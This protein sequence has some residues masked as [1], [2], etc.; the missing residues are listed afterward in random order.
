MQNTKILK[1]VLNSGVGQAVNNPQF[2]ENT[3]QILNKIA[4]GQKPILTK[5]RNSITTFKIREG[6]KIGCKVTLRR[7]K[8]F[9]FLFQLINVNLPLITN[10]RGLSLKKF[11][12]FGNYNFGLNEL[13]IFPFVPYELTFKN[14]GLQ[15]TIVFKSNV[16]EENI[17]FLK[18]FGFP[19]T[20]K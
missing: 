7:K 20:N 11:D 13:T 10:F 9:D 1:I 2:L 4:Q 6:L 17:Y 5:A 14:Q 19:F 15:V 18:S 12:K 8:T 3:K 16:K